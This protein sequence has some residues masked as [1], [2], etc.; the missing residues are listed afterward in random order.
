MNSTNQD[1][2]ENTTIIFSDTHFTE[3]FDDN[4]YN[5]LRTIIIVRCPSTV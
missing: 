5:Y 2:L 3:K 1:Y 4:T